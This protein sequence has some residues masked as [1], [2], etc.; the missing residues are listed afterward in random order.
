MDNQSPLIW[1][2]A[3]KKF[4]LET[5][6]KIELTALEN[7]QKQP[8]INFPTCFKGRPN[9]W[10]KI[11]HYISCNLLGMCFKSL[12][13][14]LRNCSVWLLFAY[15]PCCSFTYQAFFVSIN[16]SPWPINKISNDF[17]R[18]CI[19]DFQCTCLRLHKIFLG[20]YWY[21]Y[22]HHPQYLKQFVRYISRNK[23]DF[24]LPFQWD[25][26]CSE[27]LARKGTHGQHL[28]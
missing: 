1:L 19:Q 11:L 22:L 4:W 8:Q 15:N 26:T 9:F 23:I 3:N 17:C 25:S 2:Q 27:T 16:K 24:C 10:T 6:L 28:W 5:D 14:P 13:G 18:S 7:P 12:H 21:Q 20:C